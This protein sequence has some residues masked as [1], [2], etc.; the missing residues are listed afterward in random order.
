MPKVNEPKVIVLG[1][2][3]KVAPVVLLQ[4]ALSPA[5]AQITYQLPCAVNQ[6]DATAP[7]TGQTMIE[8]ATGKTIPENT[9]VDLTVRVETPGT[10][11]QFI[12]S[13]ISFPETAPGLKRS[14]GDTPLNARSCIAKVSFMERKNVYHDK[15]SPALQ[16]K[17]VYH[18]KKP[19]TLN[20]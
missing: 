12:Q 1:C 20:P 17:S 4:L 7:R 8:N 5:L 13:K 9:S 6:T 18:D 15:K 16:D 14:G 10:K 11:V 2:L 3:H 19:P